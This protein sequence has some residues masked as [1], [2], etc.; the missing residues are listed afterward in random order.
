[1]VPMLGKLAPRHDRRTLQLSAFVDRNLLPATQPRRD[2]G[3]RVSNWGMLANNLVG[4][5]TIA[6]GAHLAMAMAANT[7]KPFRPSDAQ[8][9]ADYSRVSGYDPKTGANDNGA[10][11]LDVMKFWRTSGIC[12]HK[13]DGFVAVHPLDHQLIDFAIDYLGGVIKGVNLPLAAKRMTNLWSVPRH[14][15][16]YQWAPGT[17]GGHAVP[18]IGYD[19]LLGL[20]RTVTWGTEINC[21]DAFHDRYCDEVFAVIDIVDWL[22]GNKVTPSGLDLAKLEKYWGL[23]QTLAA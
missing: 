8:A 19:R 1:M 16:G 2:W 3:Q 12:G 6:G 15:F 18:D 10:V 13:I 7:G 14:P 21:T 22:G 11:L 4:N 17:W 9:I 20:Y 5:C 23:A